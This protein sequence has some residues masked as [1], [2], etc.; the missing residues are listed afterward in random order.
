MSDATRQREEE[1]RL[2]A[3][4]VEGMRLAFAMIRDA[5]SFDPSGPDQSARRAYIR[6]IG[7]LVEGIVALLKQTCLAMHDDGVPIPPIGAGSLAMLREESYWLNSV[8]M[9]E[10]RRSFP[11]TAANVAFTLRVFFEATLSSSRVETS[12]EGWS[13]FIAL[14]GIRNRITHPK[15]AAEFEVS[16][17]DLAITERGTEWFLRHCLLA[18]MAISAYIAAYDRH[19][20]AVLE[21]VR[22]AKTP[23]R[24]FRLFD[25]LAA[26]PSRELV[27]AAEASGPSLVPSQTANDPSDRETLLRKLAEA[28]EL[29]SSGKVFKIALSRHA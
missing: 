1:E 21:E 16:E 14:I 19:T 23:D 12:G 20:V 8:G 22:D 26:P 2:K 5:F 24:R 25:K 27:A 15:S 10:F 28:E 13:G 6:A 3:S 7:A 18:V 29:V 9:V 11:P 17:S 4:L